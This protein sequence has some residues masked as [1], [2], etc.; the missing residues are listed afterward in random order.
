MLLE[1][2]ASKELLYETPI[3]DLLE[4]MVP[5]DEIAALSRMQNHQILEKSSLD[6]TRGLR[7]ICS[8]LGKTTQDFI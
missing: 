1:G 8:V 2:L 3:F 6:L 7:T 4:A 5:M